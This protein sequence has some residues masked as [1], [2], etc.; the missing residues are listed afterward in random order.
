MALTSVTWFRLANAVTNR[1]QAK[2][3]DFGLAKVTISMDDALGMS[4][5]ESI[6]NLDAQI[7]HRFHLQWL[8]SDPVPER[9]PLQ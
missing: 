7:E 8:A 1:G 2:I 4:R 9:L 6:G 5:V 3:L